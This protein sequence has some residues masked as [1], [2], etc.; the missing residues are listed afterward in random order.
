[1]E[2]KILQIIHLSKEDETIF[3]NYIVMVYE[4]TLIFI[5][6][7]TMNYVSHYSLSFSLKLYESIINRYS[8]KFQNN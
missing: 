5:L 7:E 8:F 2:S 6:D 1:M 4:K 3:G